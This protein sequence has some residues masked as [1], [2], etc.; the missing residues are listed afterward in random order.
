MGG[1][2]PSESLD[3]SSVMYKNFCSEHEAQQTSV[4]DLFPWTG[5]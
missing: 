5:F 1:N 4:G 2:N 3:L